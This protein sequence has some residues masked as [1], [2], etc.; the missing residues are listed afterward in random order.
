MLNAL[1][2]AEL[3]G[4]EMQQ[5]ARALALVADHRCRA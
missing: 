3:L 5:L 4:F 2:A 1:Y